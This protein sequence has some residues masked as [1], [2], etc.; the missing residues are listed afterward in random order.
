MVGVAEAGEEGGGWCIRA[1]G[2]A[3]E[4][5]EK[6]ELHPGGPG[7]RGGGG[8][9]CRGQIGDVVEAANPTRWR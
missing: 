2:I 5:V 3:R 1:F 6:K 4:A 7:K 9:R 8:G